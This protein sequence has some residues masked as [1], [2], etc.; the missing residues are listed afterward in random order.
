[1]R[2]SGIRKT[3]KTG[4]VVFGGSSLVLT[5]L[6]NLFLQ[7]LGLEETAALSW[8]MRMIGITVFAL[9]GNMWQNSNHLEE[10]RVRNSAIIMAISAFFLG[11]ITLAIP[12]EITLFTLAYAA[13]GFGFSIA[14]VVNL[15]LKPRSNW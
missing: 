1:M 6:P 2:I 9:A 8:S 4:A 13:I 14:Y 3:L 11:L 10:I 12:A 5:F 7:L 15:L